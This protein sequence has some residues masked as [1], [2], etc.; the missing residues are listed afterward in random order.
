MTFLIWTG[1]IAVCMVVAI[2]AYFIAEAIADLFEIEDE[3]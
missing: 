2:V 1:I 3:D